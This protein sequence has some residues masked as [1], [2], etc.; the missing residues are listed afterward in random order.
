MND[1]YVYSAIMS[2][3]AIIAGIIVILAVALIY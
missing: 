1:E 3:L 2:M